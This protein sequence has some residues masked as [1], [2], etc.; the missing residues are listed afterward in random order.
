MKNILCAIGS[1]DYQYVSFGMHDKCKRCGKIKRKANFYL[2][3]KKY[4]EYEIRTTVHSE[5]TKEFGYSWAFSSVVRH[6]YAGAFVDDYFSTD[7]I[8]D[9]DGFLYQYNEHI[10]I[11]ENFINNIVTPNKIEEKFINILNNLDEKQ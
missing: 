2:K 3:C 5:Y 1:H 10:F 11:I 7:T 6:K 8:K 4:K 9:I